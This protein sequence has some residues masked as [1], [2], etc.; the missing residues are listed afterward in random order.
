MSNI[1]SDIKSMKTRSSRTITLESLKY[2]KKFA[3]KK[4]FEKPF[5]EKVRQLEQARPTTTVM[6][7]NVLAKVKKKPGINTIDESIELIESLQ[8]KINKHAKVLRGRIMIHCNSTELNSAIIANRSRI[9]EVYVTETEPRR[10]GLLSAKELMKEKIK[11]KFITDAAA[12]YY[13]QDV[14]MV[15]VGADAITWQGV[16]NK[17]GTMLMA[18]AADAFN[19]PLYVVANTLKYHKEKVKI[20]FRD[21]D[22]VTKKLRDSVILNPG[23]DITPWRYVEGVIT[24]QGIKRP[25]QILREMRGE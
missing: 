17:I 5:Y 25:V 3:K 20:E 4:G 16:V 2:L 7:A 24:E 6:L 9:K 13:M 14:D 12:G 18:T 10:Q 19:K 11:I 1:V 15:A 23:F 22:E 8:E 21:P